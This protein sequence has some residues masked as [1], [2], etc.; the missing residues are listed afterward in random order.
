METEKVLRDLKD[1]AT[2]IRDR[3]R[4]TPTGCRENEKFGEWLDTVFWVCY[5]IEEAMREE[6][7]GK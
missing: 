2:Y 4:N 3:K 5:Q 7:D 1:I 6:D